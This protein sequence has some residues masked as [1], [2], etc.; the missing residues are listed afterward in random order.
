MDY[1]DDSYPYPPC[2]HCLKAALPPS[3]MIRLIPPA[4]LLTSTFYPGIILKQVEMSKRLCHRFKNPP[5]KGKKQIYYDYRPC[6]V[7]ILEDH[8]GAYQIKILTR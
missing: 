8:K 5:G 2:P 7:K 3:E 1:L 6:H 4:K